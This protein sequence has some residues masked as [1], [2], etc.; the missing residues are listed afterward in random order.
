MNQDIRV[1]VNVDRLPFIARL[2]ATLGAEGPWRYVLL[3]C[4]AGEQF[5]SGTFDLSSEE[6]ESMVGWRGQ[7]GEFVRTLL[8]L[9]ELQNGENGFSLTRWVEWNSYAAAFPIRSEVGKKN[10]VRGW[11]MRRGILEGEREVNAKPNGLPNGLP[12]APSPPPPPPPKEGE[13]GDAADSVFN[14]GGGQT[15]PPPVSVDELFSRFKRWMR[16]T[17]RKP[18]SAELR[19]EFQDAWLEKTSQL[20]PDEQMELQRRVDKYHQRAQAK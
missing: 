11:K 12:Y 10:A 4:L 9:G 20:E 5:Y 8:E 16:E 2:Y 6:L 7:P 3:H 15:S 18:P 17:E 13:G 14:P 1:P 19:K